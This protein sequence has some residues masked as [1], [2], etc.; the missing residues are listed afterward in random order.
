MSAR[1]L[2]PEGGVDCD[3]PLVGKKN[4][5]PFI[6]VWKSSPSIRVLKP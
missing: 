5:P 6:R 3:V 1:T 4:K 2:G